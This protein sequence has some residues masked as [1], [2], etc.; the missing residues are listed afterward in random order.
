M[1]FLDTNAEDKIKS[2]EVI[3]SSPEE[4]QTNDEKKQI[5]PRE[6]LIVARNAR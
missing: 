2:L 1:L 4:R 6:F 3:I 5:T